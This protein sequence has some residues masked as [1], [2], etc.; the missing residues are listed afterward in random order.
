[1][2]ACSPGV[3]PSYPL[4]PWE[5]NSNADA[6]SQIASGAA[7]TPDH[8]TDC[9]RL[10]ALLEGS[11]SDQLEDNTLGARQRQDPELDAAINYREE[12]VLPE[13]DERAR[14]LV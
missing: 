14:E 4:S 7:V 13:N 10:G 5:M 11:R 1:M 2:G 8:L 9:V 6:L 12:G 3:I